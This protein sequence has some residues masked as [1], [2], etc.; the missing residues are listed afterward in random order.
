MLVL[1]FASV[2][3]LYFMALVD[4]YPEYGCNLDVTHWQDKIG[5]QDSGGA[6]AVAPINKY[7]KNRTAGRN[8]KIPYF[9]YQT[10]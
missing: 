5:L 2:F 3:T 4:K 10:N 8:Q 9:I 1:V 6:Q 7:L